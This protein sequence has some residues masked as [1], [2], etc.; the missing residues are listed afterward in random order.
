[1][2]LGFAIVWCGLMLAYSPMADCIATRLATEPPTLNTFRAIQKS[3]TKLIVGIVVA[4]ILGGILEELVFRGIVLKSVESLLSHW[5]SEPLGI[6]I[7]ICVA[8]NGAG[9]IHIYQGPRGVIII[10]QLSVLFGLLFT[11]SGFNLW[12]VIFCHGLYDTVAFIRFA[13]KKSRYSDL[14]PGHARTK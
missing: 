1:M 9:I 11:L 12:P 4:W 5:M 2:T 7:A 6:A 3:R 14:A 13:N 10:V 8:A